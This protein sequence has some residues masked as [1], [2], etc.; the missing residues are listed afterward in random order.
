MSDQVHSTASK[1]NVLPHST[2]ATASEANES[3]TA[4]ST[5]SAASATTK[6]ALANTSSVSTKTLEHTVAT[7]AI[8]AT[9]EIL[10]AELSP[11]EHTVLMAVGVHVLIVYRSN[12]AIRVICVAEISWSHAIAF[13]SLVGVVTIAVM[14]IL[15]AVINSAVWA[16]FVA[17]VH[18]VLVMLR[19]HGTIRVKVRSIAYSWSTGAAST[20]ITTMAVFLAMIDA[21]ESAVLVAE[22][23]MVLVMGRPSNAIRIVSA[24][25]ESTA[26]T[27]ATDIT[28]T[29]V[30]TQ[31]TRATHA[32][33][34]TQVGKSTHTGRATHAGGT[35]TKARC[36]LEATHAGRAIAGTGCLSEATHAGKA[37]SETRCLLEST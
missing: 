7:G 6:A 8:F 28:H 5:E 3:A 30:T 17:G 2:V 32:G 14:A 4:H 21:A 24:S 19:S 16:V 35:K 9:H 20:V 36:L 33:G 1:A 25:S 29:T 11:V 12:G 34:A 37:L 15:L 31:A 13:V 10:L 22:S 18:K 26:N 23:V 27:H